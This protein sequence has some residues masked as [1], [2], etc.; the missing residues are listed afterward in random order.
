MSRLLVLP[1]RAGSAVDNM[2]LDL[3]LLERALQPGVLLFRHYTWNE[4]AFTFGVSQPFAYA[5]SVAGPG[6]APVRR[7]TGG[8]V[9]NHLTDWT[10][11]LLAPAGHPLAEMKATASYRLVHEAVVVA[12]AACGVAA[13]LVPCPRESC[14]TGVVA[15]PVA[16][17][18]PGA[19]FLEPEVY[20]V[21]SPSGGRKLAGAAQKRTRAGILFQGYVD[22]PGCPGA[23]WSRFHTAFIEA[24]AVAC[25]VT[26][27]RYGEM[28]V[29]EEDCAG[30]RALFA[31]RDWN[32]RR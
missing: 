15:T 6:I 26:P 20:D 29:T 1:D 16:P 24:L 23:D 7:A 18:R 21:I 2:A 28:P 31:S 22:R 12:L 19:C 5:R 32:E 13:A 17:R 10:Y 4:P 25:G 3:T 11:A 9:V 27:V 30:A 14:T 8:G